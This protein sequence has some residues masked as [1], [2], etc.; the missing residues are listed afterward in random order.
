MAL[1]MKF[2]QPSWNAIQK[3]KSKP[4]KG[5]QKC[6]CGRRTRDYYPVRLRSGKIVAVCV[7]CFEQSVREET[8]GEPSWK[9]AEW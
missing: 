9:K 6:A 4:P 1:A 2:T 5:K 8:R 3:H 7:P